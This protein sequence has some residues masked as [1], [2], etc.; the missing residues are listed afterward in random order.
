MAKNQDYNNHSFINK[1]YLYVK[2]LNEEKYQYLNKREIPDLR[3]FYDFKAFIKYTNE[4]DDTY[5]NFEEDNP[6][7]KMKN[8]K[9]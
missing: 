3:R 4:M 8:V 2:D 6:N 9:H 5:K 1:I 7:E